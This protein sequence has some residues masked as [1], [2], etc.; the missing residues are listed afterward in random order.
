MN[1]I[2]WCLELYEKPEIA[3]QDDDALS[4][5]PPQ[6]NIQ[7]GLLKLWPL[8]NQIADGVSLFVGHMVAA[9]ML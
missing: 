5:S 1:A 3:V 6:Y 9:D 8:P 7:S 4:R 2:F